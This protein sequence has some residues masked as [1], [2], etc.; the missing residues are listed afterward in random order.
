MKGSGSSSERVSVILQFFIYFIDD[1]MN[2][3]KTETYLDV[4]R[5]VTRQFKTFF[6]AIVYMAV[7]A[8]NARVLLNYPKIVS[9]T[10]STLITVQYSLVTCCPY[11]YLV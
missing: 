3:W 1:L 8:L 2:N 7:N 9:T 4:K 10:V 6:K 11:S 5:D